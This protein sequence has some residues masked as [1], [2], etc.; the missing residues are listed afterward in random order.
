MRFCKFIGDCFFLVLVGCMR[1]M[2]RDVRYFEERVYVG[3]IGLCGVGK[4]E[5]E[6]EGSGSLV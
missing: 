3:W 5:M 1:V 6:I 2:D 4:E